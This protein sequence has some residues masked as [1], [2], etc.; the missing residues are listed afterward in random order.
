MTMAGT[1]GTRV[2]LQERLGKKR[3]ILGVFSTSTDK[4]AN[5]VKT[6]MSLTTKNILEFK[7]P[8]YPPNP[9]EKFTAVVHGS[10]NPTVPVAGLVPRP[11]PIIEATV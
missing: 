3:Q 2:H 6:T 7:N 4:L 1:Q 11:F 9:R 5:G 8:T 10:P